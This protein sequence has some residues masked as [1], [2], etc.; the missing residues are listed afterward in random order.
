MTTKTPVKVAKHTIT[1]PERRILLALPY[2]RS[3]IYR[4][5]PL[6]LTMYLHLVTLSLL[7]DH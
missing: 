2:S 7:P 4:A 1:F 6:S 5:L 3:D